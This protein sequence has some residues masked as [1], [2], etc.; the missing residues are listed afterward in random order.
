MNSE[1]SCDKLFSFA[2]TGIIYILKCVIIEK[3]SN[4]ISQYYCIF[5]QI[6]A[7]L[8]NHKSIL[9]KTWKNF[10][11]HKFLKSSNVF[12]YTSYNNFL[13]FTSIFNFC[14]LWPCNLFNVV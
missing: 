13:F 8:V 14:N 2:I 9:S 5:Y 6:N 10:A 3:K 7:A 12:S 11:D 1:G 4:N